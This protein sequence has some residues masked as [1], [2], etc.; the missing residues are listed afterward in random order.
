MDAN[1][2]ILI[3]DDAA[4]FR[5]LGSVFLART[6]RV[7]TA[8]NGY[9]CLDLLRSERP[10]VLVADLDM[11][12]MD[13]EEL[14]R[15]MKADEE[16]RDIP[17]ILVTGSEDG[18]ER[19]RAVRA[20]ADDVVAKPISRIA[21]IQA[22]NRF[23]R[24]RP[25]RGLARVPLETNVRVVCGASDL[26]ARSRNL[27]RGGMFIETDEPLPPETEVALEFGLPDGHSP[28]A[29]TA[30][31]IWSG[32][33]EAGDS[34]GMGLQFLALDGTYLDVSRPDGVLLLEDI[35]RRAEP[36]AKN[37]SAS[38]WDVG[39]GV[40]CFEIHTK[41][42]T[43]DPDCQRTSSIMASMYSCSS[44]MGLVS[45]KRRLHKPPS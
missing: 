3:A 4:M 17:V 27:S 13:G 40:V 12:C 34:R 35:K 42:N 16:L 23:M 25:V 11:P 2:T 45:S 44:L 28:I 19:A 43:I 29:P 36:L 7:I 1:R 5:E 32:D 8:N 18:Q 41:L 26:A 37:G 24:S 14:C 38:L 31:V 10:S 22:V 6:G 21:L 20:G 30:Q 33:S 39:D 15:R 9:E